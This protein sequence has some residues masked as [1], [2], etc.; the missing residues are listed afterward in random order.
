MPIIKPHNRLI[1]LTL[2]ILSGMAVSS[3]SNNPESGYE[4]ACFGDKLN[5]E[6]REIAIENGWHINESYNCVDK[7]SHEKWAASNPL[8]ESVKTNL[9][10]SDHDK[11]LINGKKQNLI[12][13]ERYID[14]A[15]IN[16]N[17]LPVEV[18][19]ADPYELGNIIGIGNATGWKIKQIREELPFTDWDDLLARVPVLKAGETAHEASIGGMTV[20][21]RSMPGAFHNI[22]ASS[23]IYEKQLRKLMH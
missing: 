22:E 1:L 14:D 18:N 11:E 6:T 5:A 13:D 3:C 17:K 9:S 12:D 20:S 15:L 7:S 23:T 19:T 10:A 8:K 4:L 16:M 21:G 2:V